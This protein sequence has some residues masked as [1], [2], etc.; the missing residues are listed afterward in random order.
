MEG[1]EMNGGLFQK[2]GL[3]KSS[4]RLTLKWRKL[5]SILVIAGLLINPSQT[6]ETLKTSVYI[7]N[8]IEIIQS[9]P[10]FQD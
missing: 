9:F 10:S 1:M 2:A 4:S 3:V 7:E 5:S 6:Y 8:G